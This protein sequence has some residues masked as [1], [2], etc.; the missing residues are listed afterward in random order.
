ML[1]KL[2]T[3]WFEKNQV[4]NFQKSCMKQGPNHLKGQKPR[5]LHFFG[6]DKGKS[7][8]TSALEK[9]LGALAPSFTKPEKKGQILGREAISPIENCSK[10]NYWKKLRNI[11]YFLQ[12]SC[13][14]N[15]SC[16]IFSYQI[17]I[18]KGLGRT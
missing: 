4:T 8:Y 10:I 13:N 5:A 15:R 1:A 6:T 14:W 2:H 7:R 11:D 18:S 9:T 16:S 3:I 12:V 17:G